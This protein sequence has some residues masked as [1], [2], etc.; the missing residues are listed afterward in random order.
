[1]PTA[2]INAKMSN[3]E[4][5]QKIALTYHPGYVPHLP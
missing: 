2:S 1:M 4:F 5:F 3:E